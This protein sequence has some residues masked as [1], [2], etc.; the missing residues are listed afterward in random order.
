MFA[1]EIP[2]YKS[3]TD[4]RNRLSSTFT[5]M[6]MV[7]LNVEAGGCHCSESRIEASNNLTFSKAVTLYTHHGLTDGKRYDVETYE[8]ERKI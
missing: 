6:Y 3:H 5:I 7:V 8:L 4:L 2:A 1:N